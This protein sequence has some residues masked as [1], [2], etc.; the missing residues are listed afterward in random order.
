MPLSTAL[1]APSIEFYG[2][3]TYPTGIVGAQVLTPCPADDAFSKTR[4][5][6]NQGPTQI[7]GVITSGG[8]GVVG[9]NYA[10]VGGRPCVINTSIGTPAGRAWRTD[11]WQPGWDPDAF[12]AGALL[13]PPSVVAVWDFHVAATALAFAAGTDDQTGFWF[14]P[15]IPVMGGFT[16]GTP[17]GASPAGGFGIALNNNAG[18]NR[19]E[20]VSYD[21]GGAI[22]QR[23]ELVVPDV[24]Q[25]SSFRMTLISAAA[26][27]AATLSLQVNREN[28]GDVQ[29][30][31]FDD[32]VLM[33]PNT[34]AA[35][36]TNFAVGQT[37][38]PMGGEGLQ[39]AIFARFGRFTASGEEI[40]GI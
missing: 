36:A 15:L 30:L 19:W 20:F 21:D 7:S 2:D 13:N 26:G 31:P 33:R 5:E 24:T 8:S 18:P 10:V 17:G 6:S 9:P 34:L 40:Q 32:V 39:F 12:N 28:V 1:P 27:R 3:F 35:A 37:L 14:Q 25:W 22:L 38:G 23:T 29:G 4:P 11:I 16:V